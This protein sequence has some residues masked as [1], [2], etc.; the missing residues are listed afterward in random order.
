MS[1]R[2]H[3]KHEVSNAE[4]CQIKGSEK[5]WYKM[6]KRRIANKLVSDVLDRID[7]VARKER[8]GYVSYE[9]SIRVIDEDEYW[10]LVAYRKLVDKHFG[11][12]LGG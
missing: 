9:G 7:F 11:E 1:E 12:R 10:E 2:L 6:M 4:W 8:S 3:V 5:A